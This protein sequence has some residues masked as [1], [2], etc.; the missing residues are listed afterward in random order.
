MLYDLKQMDLKV[1]FISIIYF[2]NNFLLI[3]KIHVSSFGKEIL[4]QNV[5]DSINFRVHH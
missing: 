4:L 2:N 5:K 3:F 1:M